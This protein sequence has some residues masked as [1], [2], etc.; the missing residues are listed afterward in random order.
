M[1]HRPQSVLVFVAVF[2]VLVG[3]CRSDSADTTTTPEDRFSEITYQS[4]DSG[5]VS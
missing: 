1:N 4:P 5:R 3:S 2:A